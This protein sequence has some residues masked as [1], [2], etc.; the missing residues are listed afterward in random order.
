M[1][2]LSLEF[3]ESSSKTRLSQSGLLGKSSVEASYPI[4]AP[5]LESVRVLGL[6]VDS[7]LN[8]DICDFM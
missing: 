4:L 8:M 1:V 3:D 5:W 2:A 7:R 6:K